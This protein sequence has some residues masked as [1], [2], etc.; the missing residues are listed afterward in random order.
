MEMTLPG[1]NAGSPQRP[2]HG[3]AICLNDSKQYG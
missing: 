2:H 1:R 3:I